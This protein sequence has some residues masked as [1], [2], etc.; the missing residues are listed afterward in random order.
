M[1][2]IPKHVSIIMDG[3]GRWA[4]R[5]GLERLAGHRA[6]VESVKAATE[7]AA[8]NGIGYLSLFAFS[9]E[10][11]NRPEEEIS[12]LMELMIDAIINE[13][14]ALTENNIKFLVIGDLS[15]F[16]ESLSA[17]IEEIQR[18]T[19]LNTGLVLI[20]FLS[21]SG[22]WDIVQA[23]NRYL[24]SLKSGWKES[25]SPLTVDTFSTYLSTADIPDP[26]LLI[27]T[28]GEQRIS[29]YMLWQCAYTEFFFTEVLWPDF[30]KNDFKL[31][32]DTYSERERRYGK[33]G[34][35]INKI[36]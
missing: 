30:R 27:R 10:N 33:T 1:N 26:D 7:F 23:V 2:K 36:K 24:T 25:D 14:K 3:N 16:S 31:A 34:D 11:W 4:K 19:A 22:R 13:R 5:R 35:Q 17:K 9:E 28:S 12:G 21:Y 15:R 29:N 8:E 6:G 18:I 20:V 32:L